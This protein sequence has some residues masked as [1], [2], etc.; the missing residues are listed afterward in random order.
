MYSFPNFESVIVRCLILTVASRQVVG[1]LE[2]ELRNELHSGDVDL[3][4]VSNIYI[5]TIKVSYDCH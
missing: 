1:I 3:G 5:G 4:A 2:S